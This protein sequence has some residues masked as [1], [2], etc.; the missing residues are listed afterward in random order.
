MKIV[1]PL[2]AALILT[3]C[4]QEK[5]P[6]P[7]KDL[8]SPTNGERVTDCSIRFKKSGLCLSWGWE[9][10]PTSTAM[11]S[12]VFK[13]Y[14]ANLL[15]QSPVQVDLESTPQVILWMPEM[16]HGSRP[17]T[18]NPIDV[19]TYRASDVFF[20]MPGKWEI[21]FQIKSGESV[22]DEAVVNVTI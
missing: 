4:A 6:P 16:G 12:L 10:Q 20:V 1:T 13:T 7:A 15:D 21:L 14:R 11:G 3:A 19:G 8:F 5:S 22:L 17:T 2:I 9:S 18:V